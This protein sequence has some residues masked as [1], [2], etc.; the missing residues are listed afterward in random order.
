MHPCLNLTPKIRRN[1]FDVMP[2]LLFTIQDSVMSNQAV[3]TKEWLVDYCILLFLIASFSK[4]SIQYPAVGNE[5]SLKSE[6]NKGIEDFDIKCLFHKYFVSML[7]SFRPNAFSFNTNL[8]YSFSPGN[9]C[10]LMTLTLLSGEFE[11][12]FL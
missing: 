4:G 9:Y 1:S 11:I 6:G 10:K 2:C 12:S 5:I 7:R 8:L 3:E